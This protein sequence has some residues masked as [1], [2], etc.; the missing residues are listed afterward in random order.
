MHIRNAS[1]LA[2]DKLESVNAIESTEFPSRPM[3]LLKHF[4]PDGTLSSWVWSERRVPASRAHV[5]RSKKLL[6]CSRIAQDGSSI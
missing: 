3:R 6:F 5:S 1:G 4:Q 2:F